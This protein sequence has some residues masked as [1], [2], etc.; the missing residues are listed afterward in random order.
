MLADLEV[1]AL[2]RVLRPTMLMAIALGVVGFVVAAL[3]SAPLAAVGIAV[4]VGLAILNLR[5]LAAGVVKVQIDDR[6]D[7]KVIKRILRTRSLLRL[8]V[9]TAIVIGAMLIKPALGM[10]IVIGLVIFQLAFVVN[11]G[12]AV[13]REGIS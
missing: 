2:S 1:G 7:S 12:R 13:L 9:L 10:G 8:S 3:L 4:G 6:G 5:L 11:A